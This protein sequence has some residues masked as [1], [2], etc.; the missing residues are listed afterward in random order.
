MA[1]KITSERPVTLKSQPTFTCS[2]SKNGNAKAM[3]EIYSKF[4]IKIPE[5]DVV[6]VSSVNFEQPILGINGWSA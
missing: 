6:L 2:K 5:H 4:I 3:G 1:Q